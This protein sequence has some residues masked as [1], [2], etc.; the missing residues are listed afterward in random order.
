MI[1]KI[2]IAVLLTAFYGASHAAD[3]NYMAKLSDAH[4]RVLNG[5]GTLQDAL[6]AGRLEGFVMAVA[7]RISVSGVLCTPDQVTY[8]QLVAITKKAVREEP[9]Q[10]HMNGH[11]IVGVALTK[12]F[13]CN[14]K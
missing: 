7:D 10:W 14:K 13:P 3:G 9:D 11:Y 6:D 2:L 8:E 4:D 5:K 12:A 1:R